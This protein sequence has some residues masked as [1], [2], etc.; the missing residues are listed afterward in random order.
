M[1]KLISKT[2]ELKES[3]YEVHVGKKEHSAFVIFLL[4]KD[5]HIPWC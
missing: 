4:C 1:A 5:S 2:S 3:K